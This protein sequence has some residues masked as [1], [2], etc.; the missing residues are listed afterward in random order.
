M[1][2]LL[3]ADH[4]GNSLTSATARALTAAAQL[5]GDVHVL[6]AGA[7]AGD[8]AAAAARLAGVTK[9][10]LA[11]APA[12]AHQLPIPVADLLVSLAPA[13]DAVL[14]AASSNGKATMPRVAA[15]LDMMQI[16][17]IVAVQGPTV[18]RRPTYAGNAIQ[19]VQSS[20]SKIV[21]T[22]RAS[23]FAAAGETGNAPI[24]PIQFTPVATTSEF[25][26][27][28]PFKS[29]RPELAAA[30]VVVSGGRAFGSAAEFDRLLLPLADQLGAAIGAS[31]AAVDAGYAP[32]SYQ[33][34]QTGTIVAPDLYIAVGI[35]GAIQHVAGMKEAKVIV[36]INADPDAPIFEIADYGLVADIFSALPELEAA[37]KARQET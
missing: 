3:L 9:V 7:D 16:S 17:E 37:L 8:V 4:D 13:Y 14:A 29:D 23:A 27:N 2:T 32:N 1:T 21:A 10:L 31:R 12:F 30:R 33:V 6:V 20:D 34:G 36:A 19:T 15:L 28:L 22:V 24:E 18:F 11:D 5:G 35:S 26:E 25:V